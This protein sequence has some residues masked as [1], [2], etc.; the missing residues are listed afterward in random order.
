[1]N[2]LEIKDL[3]YVID[4]RLILKHVTGTVAKA[5]CVVI[6]GHN[7]SGKS[8][9]LKLI[10]E[11]RPGI[12]K[13]GKS[14]MMHQTIND[15]LFCGLTILENFNLFG[16]HDKKVMLELLGRFKSPLTLQT[17]VSNLSGG[18]R[19]RLA[20]Y[21][22]IFMRPDILLL[23]EFTSALDPVVSQDLMA[24]TLTITQQ[25]HITALIV[26][27]D[28]DLIKEK[29]ILYTHWDMESGVLI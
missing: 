3:S 2:S 20:L 24:E 12:I 1:M 17:I 21:M 25:R 16:I 29:G 8:T 10:H 13:Q 15:N 28:I 14:V 5:E 18:E 11:G 4:N 23:D 26:T 19:Q 9:L 6:T 7:G 22:R 27:H